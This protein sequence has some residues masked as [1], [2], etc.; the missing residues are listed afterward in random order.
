VLRSLSL[1]ALVVAAAMLGVAASASATQLVVNGGFE[2]GN[3]EGW[4]QYQSGS[5]WEVLGAEDAE[6]AGIKFLP[7]EGSYSAYVGPTGP[8]TAILYQDVALPAGT[9]D[10][11]KLDFGYR[12]ETA[13]LE[14]GQQVRIDVMDPS[15]PPNSVAPSDIL[16]TVFATNAGSLQELVPQTLT[17]DLSPFAGQTVRLRFAVTNTAELDAVLDDVSIESTPLPV[18][19]PQPQPS[20]ASPLPSNAFSTGRLVLDRKHGGAKLNVTLPGPGRLT[21]VD[22]RRQIAI[23][24][25][26]AS[27]NEK[28]ILIRTASAQTT[29]PQTVRVFLRPTGAAKKLLGKNGKLPFRLQLTFAPEGG[30]AGTQGYSGTLLKKLRPAR[31]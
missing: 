2:T 9:T 5:A 18:P 22:A 13:L 12:S 19:Q 24:S 11:L 25:R 23:A 31:R 17:A 14:S 4:S 27:S 16:A 3:L 7:S 10:Q 20:P 1:A 8:G 21:V 6:E 29:G 26:R 15:A 30:L 28:P